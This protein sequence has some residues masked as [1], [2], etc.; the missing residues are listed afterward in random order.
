MPK[1]P[2]AGRFVGIGI[3]SYGLADRPALAELPELPSAVKDV[4][5]LAHLLSSEL[6]GEPLVNPTK[7]AIEAE[8]AD[9]EGSLSSGGSVVGLWSGH[10]VASAVGVLQLPAAGARKA[11]NL[12]VTADAFVAACIRTGANQILI[13]LDTCHS[14]EAAVDAAHVAMRLLAER[15]PEG[16]HVWVGILTS[17]QPWEPARDG[18]FA[19]ELCRLLT[20]GPA[21]PELRVYRWSPHQRLL[22]GDDLCDTVLKEWSSDRQTPRFVATGSAWRIVPNPLFR[23][24]AARGVVEHLLRAARG[25]GSALEA[26]AFTGRQSQVDKVVGWVRARVPGLHVVTGPPGTGKS[27]IVGRVVSLADPDERHTLEREPGWVGWG[28]ADPGEGS[29][30]AHVH[31][32]ALTAERMANL[33]DDALIGS[34][35]L[36]ATPDGQSRNAALLVGQLQQSAEAANW[37]TPVIVVDGLDEARG[38]VYGIVDDLLLRLAPFV[39][40]IVATREVT[41]PKGRPD[42]LD[43]LAPK[44][45]GVDLGIDPHSLDDLRMYLRRRLEGV[46][47]HMDVEAVFDY[48]THNVV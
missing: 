10:G 15:P 45:P 1:D 41:G 7:E 4:T 42:L 20:E 47:S 14:G 44:G 38:E 28:H 2:G 22:R 24:G 32:R 19:K 8:L 30:A 11:D 48:L 18:M 36:P 46:S 21:D 6:S 12:N 13:I 25:T 33:L 26:S 31:A 17:C 35:I 39:T 40:V 43:T 27:A 37:L 16:K 3:G 5:T 23:A 34:R 9:L 29:I